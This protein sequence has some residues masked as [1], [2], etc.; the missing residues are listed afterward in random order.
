MRKRPFF[1]SAVLMLA[2]GLGPGVGPGLASGPHGSEPF[3]AAE[4]HTWIG[5]NQGAFSRPSYWDPLGVPGADG[6]SIFVSPADADQAVVFDFS[7]TNACMLVTAPT[8]RQSSQVVFDLSGNTYALTREW[9]EVDRGSVT[10]GDQPGGIA[11]LRV[12]NGLVDARDAEIGLAGYGELMVSADGTWSAF[13]HMVS[14][15]TR[16]SGRMEVVNGGRV[17]HG[18]GFAG[19]DPRAQGQVVV[20]GRHPVVADHPSTWLVT[21]W[22][23]LGTNGQGSLSVAGGGIVDIGKCDMGVWPGSQGTAEVAGTG[24]RWQLNSPNEVSLIVGQRGHGSVTVSNGASLVSQGDTH[25]GESAGGAGDLV[26]THRGTSDGTNEHPTLEVMHSL[27]VGQ[28]G[29]GTLR[30][31]ER[32]HALVRDAVIV[33]TDLDASP[34]QASTIEVDGAESAL[35]ILGKDGEGSIIGME[36]GRRGSGNLLAISAGGRVETEYAATIGGSEAEGILSIDGDDSA[37]DAHFMFEV[38]RDGPGRVEISGGGRLVVDGLTGAPELPE[39]GKG[40]TYIGLRNEGEVT[41]RGGGTAAPSI[42]DSY[43]QLALGIEESRGHGRLNIEEGGVVISRKHVSPTDT[44]GIVGRMAGTSGEVRVRGAMSR[45]EMPDGGLT[46]GWFGDGLLDIR[47]GGSVICQYGVVGRAGGSDGTVTVASGPDEPGAE[48]W[49]FGPLS[50]GGDLLGNPGG[51][52]RVEIGPWA[53]AF[54]SGSVLVHPAGTIQMSDSLLVAE[55]GI[56][57]RG[58]CRGHGTIGGTFINVDG[59]LHPDDL[60]AGQPWELGLAN[61]YAQQGA[62]TMRVDVIGDGAAGRL[63]LWTGSATL[64]G[65]LAATIRT[66]YVPP[67]GS[68]FEILSAPGGVIGEFG[69]YQ[70]PAIQGEPVFDVVYGETA[71][72]LRTLR[73]YRCRAD[74]D[75]DMDV[76]TDDLDIFAACAQGPAVAVEDEGCRAA[77]FDGDSDVDQADFARM[78][79]CHSGPNKPAEVNC[80][81]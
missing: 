60:E 70:L 79:R 14:V 68:E 55:Q 36:V 26:L 56:T 9:D 40:L 62:A 8:D 16:D 54:V 2:A 77:D 51:R 34:G 50:V 80:T 35:S 25:I 44:A 45:W 33:G 71:V 64:A 38:G 46:V 27:V 17:E 75:L 6:R 20:Q 39:N 76:D 78:Q 19:Q 59:V 4:D 58:V 11:R 72:W 47:D 67:V 48:W 15:G 1:V 63:V 32:A 24:S 49:V 37:L 23:G 65:T 53:A 3:P 30:L 69:V 52:G 10:I 31:T 74:F 13:Q 28:E 81:E 21:G 61:D 42:L 7:P 18:H 73:E 43:A 57:L 29:V 12:V 22:F 41:V 66:G 5:P